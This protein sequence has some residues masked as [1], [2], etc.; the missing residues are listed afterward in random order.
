MHLNE[1]WK[2]VYCPVIINLCI[3]VMRIGQLYGLEKFW[4]FLKY[5]RIKGRVIDPKLQEHLRKFKSIDDFRVEVREP[6]TETESL[7]GWL[8]VTDW[9]YEWLTHWKCL[10][11][12]VSEWLMYWLCHWLEVCMTDLLCQW[13]IDWLIYC[14][15]EWLIVP[16][17]VWMTNWLCD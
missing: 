9:L 2:C 7:F 12:C 15:S 13:L 17:T 5:S 10:S 14:L 8:T 1:F 3:F 16:V 11:D 4:A 6:L